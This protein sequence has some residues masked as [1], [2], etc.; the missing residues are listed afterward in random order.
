VTLTETC[1]D[2]LPH[3]IMHIDATPDPT[4]DGAATPRIHAAQQ[5]R[6]L[7]PGTHPVSTSC[8]D[9]ELLVASQA[10][11]G[12]DLLGPTRFDHHGQAREGTGFDAQH[13]RIDW[14]QQHAL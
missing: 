1:E 3:L 13:F 11:D 4:A 14:S 6:D 7:L 10:H 9:A 12:V 2:A 5:Q 8:L